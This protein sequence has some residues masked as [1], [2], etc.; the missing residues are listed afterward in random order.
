MNIIHNDEIRALQLEMLKYI[1]DICEKNGLHC[2][3]SGGTLLG[4]V[5]HEGF[6]P[7]DDDIDVMLPRTE[8]RRLIKLVNKDN[9]RR[10]SIKVIGNSF[11]YPFAKLVDNYTKIDTFYV[12][13][14]GDNKVWIDIFPVDGLPEKENKCKIKYFE[15]QFLQ[16]WFSMSCA[17]LGYGKTRIRKIIKNLLSIPARCLNTETWGKL[18]DIESRKIPFENSKYVGVQCW[19]Y[20]FKERMPGDKWRKYQKKV[21]EGNKYYVPGCWDYY[22]KSLYGDYMTLPPVEK[23]K[24]HRVTAYLLDESDRKG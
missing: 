23:R 22:L 24:S 10:Y 16:L 18:I 3:L 7:W 1:N 17:N 9:N 20:G 5:R 12:N 11:P 14:K 19:G 21:F 8:Y 2:C 13:V 15:I 6:I 4:A